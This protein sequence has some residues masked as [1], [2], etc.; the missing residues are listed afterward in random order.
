MVPGTYLGII[1][2]VGYMRGA[3]FLDVVLQCDH[4]MHAVRTRSACLAP[5]IY[6]VHSLL[7]ADFCNHTFFYGAPAL[8][9]THDSTVTSYFEAYITFIRRDHEM[10]F[11]FSEGSAWIHFDNKWDTK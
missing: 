8:L 2:D 7:R 1:D 4:R 11:C 9:R 5:F 6:R 3:G 10:Y